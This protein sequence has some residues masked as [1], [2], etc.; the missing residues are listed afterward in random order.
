[1]VHQVN[2]HWILDLCG[3]KTITDI[4]GHEHKIKDVDIILTKS[5]FKGYGWLTENGKSW[6]DYWTAFR[7]YRHALYVTRVLRC[8][9]AGRLPLGGAACCQL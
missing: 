6:E 9:P 5:M 4:W 7:K 3:Q 1:M 8:K 2:F